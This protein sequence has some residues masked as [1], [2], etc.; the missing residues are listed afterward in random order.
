LPLISAVNTCPSTK[1]LFSLQISA[2]AKSLCK[3]LPQMESD[4]SDFFE[5]S[6]FDMMATETRKKVFVNVPLN[7]EV[8]NPGGGLALATGELTSKYFKMA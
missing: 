7:Y 8:P 4:L 3:K 2:A 6:P 5:I 1:S